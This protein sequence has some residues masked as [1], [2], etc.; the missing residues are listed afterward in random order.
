MFCYYNTLAWSILAA[1]TAAA[2]V[3][4][5][6]PFVVATELSKQPPFFVFIEGLAGGLLVVG[7]HRVGRLRDLAARWICLPEDDKLT[8]PKKWI[9]YVEAGPWVTDYSDRLKETNKKLCYVGIGLL[10]F[11]LMVTV[12]WYCFIV[13]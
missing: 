8:S 13:K 2:L 11:F 12:I 4:A 9:D 3:F 1:I 5:V 6:L 10:F 7:L